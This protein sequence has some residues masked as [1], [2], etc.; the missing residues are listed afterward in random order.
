MC[1]CFAQLWML[2]TSL[3]YDCMIRKIEF[4]CNHVNGLVKLCVCVCV[5]FGGISHT[6]A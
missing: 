6:Y 5:C 1:V 4:L 2:F 3:D